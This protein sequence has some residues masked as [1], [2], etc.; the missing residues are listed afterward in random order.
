MSD[1]ELCHTCERYGECD[2]YRRLFLIE[3][4]LLY[5]CADYKPLKT[6]EA[7]KMTHKRTENN[8]AN[9]DAPERYTFTPWGALY[10]TLLN[11]GI[12]LRFDNGDAIDGTVGAHIV[13]DFMDL[14][15]KIGYATKR[16]EETER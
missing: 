15:C 13:A 7:E 3:H 2:V 11:Y 6:D 5:S 10:A 14:L 4:N 12:H 16:E 1:L 8:N 9:A